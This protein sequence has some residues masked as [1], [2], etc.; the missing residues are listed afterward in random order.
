MAHSVAALLNKEKI[1]PRNHCGRQ[2]LFYG[3]KGDLY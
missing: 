2:G 1:T 3:I